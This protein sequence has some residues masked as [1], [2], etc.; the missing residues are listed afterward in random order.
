MSRTAI[1]PVELAR[2]VW[3]VPPLARRSDKSLDHDQNARLI[4]HLER[5]GVT[6]LLYGGNANL[7]HVPP[8]QYAGLLDML[9]RVASPESCI[10]PA[11]GPDYGRLH[12]QA[13]VLRDLRFGLAMALPEAGPASKRGIMAGL[14][15]FS[16][17]AG[18]PLVLYVKSD[19]YLSATEIAALVDDGVVGLVK[20]AVPRE[21]P[22]DDPYLRGILDAIDRGLVLSGMG[23]GP[24]VAHLLGLGLAGYTSGAVCLAPRTARA[25]L[26][27]LQAEN[28]A[29]SQTLRS[30]FLPIERIRDQHGAT[31]VLHAA[32]TASGIADMGPLL[33]LL[34]DLESEHLPMVAAAVDA[35][36]AAEHADGRQVA[37][38]QI[39]R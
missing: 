23:E 9:L 38:E 6:T 36:L 34:D 39:G 28:E 10:I 33:P 13:P 1:R 2:S 27:A 29:E 24:T 12:D 3:A 15:R 21:D 22:L 8:T 31:R 4:S 11:V 19:G 30:A 26:R 17:R 16:D 18:L 37:T 7:H 25:L 32:V 5:N 20:Y 14:R 35:L